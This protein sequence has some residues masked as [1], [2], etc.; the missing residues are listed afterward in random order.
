MRRVLSSHSRSRCT[1]P[2]NIRTDCERVRG[3][4]DCD[5]GS[6][7]MRRSSTESVT[8][9][10]PGVLAM[11]LT[12]A[13]SAHGIEPA[14]TFEQPSLLALVVQDFSAESHHRGQ[15]SRN[16]FLFFPVI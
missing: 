15:C 8:V 16:H 6:W 11:S 2:F 3:A 13:Q 9:R 14:D 10:S 4:S 7:S 12:C 1:A 5:F